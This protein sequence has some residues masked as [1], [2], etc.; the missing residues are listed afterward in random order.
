V[1]DL[2]SIVSALRAGLSARAT[3][4]WRVDG[5]RLALLAFD[6]APDMP[7]DVAD[8]F[9]AATRSV[10]LDPT[11][12]GIVGAA[13]TRAPVISVAAQLSPSLGS[14]R[15]LRAFGASRSIAVPLLGPSG[16][17]LAVLSIA[18]PD[19]IIPDREVLE[20][21]QEAALDVAT[22]LRTA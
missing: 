18:L 3:G 20:R 11:P 10:P 17:V 8:G 16:T 19:A 6:A 2:E 13:N 15:W 4:L 22:L 21:L 14:G 12:L 5:D 7:R 9:V 1:T